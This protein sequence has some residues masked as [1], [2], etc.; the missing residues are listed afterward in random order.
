V[1]PVLPGFPESVLPLL[2]R[3]GDL[4]SGWQVPPISC[5]PC[6]QARVAGFSWAIAALSGAA[7]SSAVSNGA[8]IAF[9]NLSSCFQVPIDG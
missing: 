4:V 8:V 6:M 3:L 5:S 9:I 7:R 2:D 1:L